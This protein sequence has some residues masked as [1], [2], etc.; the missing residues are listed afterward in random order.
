MICSLTRLTRKTCYGCP[1]QLPSLQQP[2]PSKNSNR[3]LPPDNCDNRWWDPIG[4]RCVCPNGSCSFTDLPRPTEGDSQFIS[5]ATSTSSRTP[6]THTSS[7]NLGPNFLQST[8]TT[9]SSKPTETGKDKPISTNNSPAKDTKT[10]FYA[11]M[12]VL[13][14]LYLIM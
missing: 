8:I 11:G 7:N 13:S 2:A 12:A 4:C 5:S 10:L 9:T 6:S 1:S 3:C 14:L